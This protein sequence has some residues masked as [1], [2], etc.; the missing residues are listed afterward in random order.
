MIPAIHLTNGSTLHV[1]R[2]GGMVNISRRN[3]AGETIEDRMF[4]LDDAVEYLANN[5]R[6]VSRKA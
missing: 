1:T 5:S 4:S 6:F 3:T 2:M